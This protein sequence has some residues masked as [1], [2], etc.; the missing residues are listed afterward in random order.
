MGQAKRRRDE[1]LNNPCI[2]CGG[3]TA[4]NTIDHIPARVFFIDRQWPEGFEF[5]ACDNCNQETRFI[6]LRLA[7][8]SRLDPTLP[9]DSPAHAEAYKLL[10]RI[11]KTEPGFIQ[12][13]L[14]PVGS[15][16]K[17]KVLS[18]FNISFN[19]LDLLE[20]DTIVS[21][22]KSMSNDVE[23]YGYKL[24]KA[25][26]WKHTGRIVPEHADLLCY[27]QS[28][29][30]MNTHRVDLIISEFLKGIGTTSRNNKH[31]E[32]QFVYRWGVS[33]DGS[34]GAYYFLFRFTFSV[35]VFLSFK[36]DGLADARAAVKEIS[37]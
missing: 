16:S 3:K 13:L 34:L 35:V 26:H 30:D 17:K 14:K 2:F 19:E 7:L 37:N 28:N 9:D 31:L 21:A 20:I 22:P 5:P 10:S 24:A 32:D 8:I 33:P 12:D 15:E 6:E 29:A 23:K 27:W 11:A 4:S 1:L 25:V 36:K 18:N